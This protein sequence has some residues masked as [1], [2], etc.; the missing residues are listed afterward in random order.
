M[1]AFSTGFVGRWLGLS[2]VRQG[3][4]IWL[5]L[6]PGFVVAMLIHGLWNF[7]GQYIGVF[8]LVLVIPIAF[9]MYKFAKE[10]NRDEA[11]WGYATGLAPKE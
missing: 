10:A 5:D 7:L 6:I 3:R 2:K 11:S 8:G 9:W 4:V 1:H